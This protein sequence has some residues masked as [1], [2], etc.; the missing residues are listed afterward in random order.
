MGK[1]TTVRRELNKRLSESKHS[2]KANSHYVDLVNVLGG[3]YDEDIE[4]QFEINMKT[5]IDQIEF[6][7]WCLDNRDSIENRRALLLEKN[8]TKE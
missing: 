8:Q 7:L 4:S 3:I 6:V 5:D 2:L 1:R